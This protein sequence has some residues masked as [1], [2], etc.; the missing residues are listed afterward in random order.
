MGENIV[1]GAWKLGLKAKEQASGFAQ[2][3][4]RVLGNEFGSVGKIDNI[5]DSAKTGA[6]KIDD[7]IV[8]TPNKLDDLKKVVDNPL[9]GTQYTSKVRE[10]VANGTDWHHAFPESVDGFA[11]IGKKT[12]FTG[13]DGVVRTRIE[14]NGNYRGKD[15]YFEWIVEP[16]KQVNHRKFIPKD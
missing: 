8:S 15:G 2:F 13:G 1:E 14:L 3:S 4:K 6:V 11:G 16:N 5:I 12:K 7:V 10:Q 9:D